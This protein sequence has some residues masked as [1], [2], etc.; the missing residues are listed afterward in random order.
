MSYPEWPNRIGERGENELP[1]GSI[2]KFTIEDE[3]GLA[4]SNLPGN[5]VFYL[6]KIQFDDGKTE[7]RLGYY[8]IGKKEGRMKGK[9]V[10]G[11]FAP[12]V[13]AEDFRAIMDAA[14]RK[15]WI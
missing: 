13:P 7:L 1:D 11:Q 9:W 4:Q 12:F 8:I 10:W 6:Q 3:I 2:E 5:K 15:G 14:H